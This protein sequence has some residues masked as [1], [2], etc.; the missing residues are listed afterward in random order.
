[1]RAA[2]RG[3]ALVVN[4]ASKLYADVGSS[5]AER[6][7]PKREL[8]LLPDLL[9]LERSPFNLTLRRRWIRRYF[10]QR[11]I[12]TMAR[13]YLSLARLVLVPHAVFSL[14]RLPGRMVARARG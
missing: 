2:E 9:L 4:P 7:F 8:K 14:A 5:W 1:M 13:Y 11:W 3:F 10:P 6:E 12:R